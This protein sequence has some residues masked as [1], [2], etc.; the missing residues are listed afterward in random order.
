MSKALI[1]F[2]ICICLEPVWAV[3]LEESPRDE[4]STVFSGRI[5]RINATA[6]LARIRT[7]FAN[8][9]F[10]N[11]RDRIDFWNESYPAQRCRAVVEGRTNDY[12]LLRVPEF[13]TC[14]RNVHFTTGTYLH[15]E[16]ADLEKT[17]TIAKELVEIL[18]KK[19]LAMRAKKERHQKELDT[20]TERVDTVNKR[21]ES[22]RQK[23]E[24]EW[25]KEIFALDEDKGRS[26]TEFKNSEA[27][28]NEI[29]AKLE[30]YRIED[31]NLKLDRW[32]LDPALYIKK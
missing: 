1:L 24:I 23:L 20:H 11:R 19:R 22:L 26:F 3:Q 21:F 15:F 18:L 31:N 4:N 7:D 25:Q 28:L 30:S 17:V 10:L 8:I 16:S 5:S 27:R 9:K 29:D 13:E 6:R 32:S 2:I 12:L 14:I